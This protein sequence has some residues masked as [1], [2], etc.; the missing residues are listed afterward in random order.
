VFNVVRRAELKQLIAEQQ[1]AAELAME[2][3]E[4]LYQ[5]HESHLTEIAAQRSRLD[6]L[7]A[8]YDTECDAAWR[9]IELQ[10]QILV[11]Q[12]AAGQSVCIVLYSHLQCLLCTDACGLV[13]RMAPSL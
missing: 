6:Q 7:K 9:Q 13:T 11:D 1:R 3:E 10:R 12:Q 4:E 5:L 8:H 2:K